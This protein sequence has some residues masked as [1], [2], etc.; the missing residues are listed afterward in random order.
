MISTEKGFVAV[1]FQQKHLTSSQL[2]DA[3]KR[4]YNKRMICIPVQDI[5][6]NHED[7]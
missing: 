3:N 4:S 6:M 5:T 2:N 1:G 7:P